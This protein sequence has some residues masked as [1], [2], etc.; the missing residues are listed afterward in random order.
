MSPYRFLALCVLIASHVVCCLGAG[1]APLYSGYLPLENKQGSSLYYAYWE[2]G[3]TTAPTRSA[4]PI[5]TNLPILLW[6]QGGPGCASSFGAFYELGPYVTDDNGKLKPNP[7]AWNKNF[8][9]LIIDQP[10]GEASSW[11]VWCQYINSC[12]AAAIAD[13]HTN[14]HVPSFGS[15]VH[16]GCPHSADEPSFLLG[17]MPPITHS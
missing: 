16:P 1:P 14:H 4:K 5:D 17:V 9:L 10:I 15:A 12:E 8:G 7:F 2:A 6:L 11:G 3:N 13:R